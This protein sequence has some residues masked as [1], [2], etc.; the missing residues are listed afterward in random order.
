MPQNSRRYSTHSLQRNSRFALHQQQQSLPHN[1]IELQS[2]Q[3]SIPTGP[4]GQNSNSNQS[5]SNS[6]GGSTAT[7]VWTP[8]HMTKTLSNKN[9]NKATLNHYQQ[10]IQQQHNVSHSP[11][12]SY[13]SQGSRN[14]VNSGTPTI[15]A[16]SAQQP[17]VMMAQV[18]PFQALPSY[19]AAG[20]T[21]AATLRRGSGA[22]GG[23]EMLHRGGNV[24]GSSSN[25]GMMST[26]KTRSSVSSVKTD[27]MECD[28]KEEGGVV[29]RGANTTTNHYSQLSQ[30]SNS[31]SPSQQSVSKT[32]NNKTNTTTANKMVQQKSEES[33]LT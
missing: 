21:P 30:L 15:L 12:A 9:L 6:I 25:S 3:F 2:H 7:Y 28:W 27:N 1:Y 29:G 32:T 33:S 8:S 31:M 24:L 10:Q 16:S 11:T 5:A 13:S 23:M 14:T 26:P 18:I 4:A 17:L 20:L 22:L 19:A